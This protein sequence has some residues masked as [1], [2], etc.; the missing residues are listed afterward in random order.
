MVL[1]RSWALTAGRACL[2][3]W[4]GRQAPTGDQQGREFGYEATAQRGTARQA[5]VGATGVGPLVPWGVAPG[6][7]TPVA[8]ARE[9]TPWGDRLTVVALSG[10]ARGG[11]SPV[12]GT[13]LAATA[14]QAWRREGWRRRRPGRRALPRTWTVLGRAERGVD[15]RWVLRR[16]T[17][18]GGPP[19]WRIHVGGPVRPTGPGRGGP[20]KPLGPEPGRAGDRERLARPAPAAPRA[21]AGPVGNP[22]SRPPGCP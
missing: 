21:P 14:T 1:A 22:G 10:V 11:A 7:G 12:A 17:R 9:A 13:V 15:A 4:L 16:S 19:C 2:A 8:L 3:P 5:W 6:E 18:L 20:W